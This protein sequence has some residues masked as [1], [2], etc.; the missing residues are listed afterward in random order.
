MVEQGRG[1]VLISMLMT[2]ASCAPPIARH[3]HYGQRD[4]HEIVDERD[5]IIIQQSRHTG[6]V[7]TNDDIDISAARTLTLRT[8][9]LSEKFKTC[10]NV[11]YS[12]QDVVGH[13]SAI[14]VA[15][16]LVLTAKHCLALPSPTKIAPDKYF[17]VFGY[18]YARGESLAKQVA[19]GQWH[20]I[21]DVVDVATPQS[22]SDWILVR[23][24]PRIQDTNLGALVMGPE[25]VTAEVYSLGHP[26]G[27]PLKVTAG[28][29]RLV[30]KAS[31]LTSLDTYPG[32]SG[33]PVFL[34]GSHRFV[35]MVAAGAGG[36]VQRGECF[37]DV[38]GPEDGAP[39]TRVIP[40]AHFIKALTDHAKWPPLP[41]RTAP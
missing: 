25:A 4:D 31:I 24:A 22:G 20:R 32:A 3:S 29:V 21:T 11:R 36:L 28:R 12:W 23:V 7:V 34:K 19:P 16:D 41:P 40:V 10:P 35:G 17:V 1:M 18:R 8:R 33:A 5:Q 39:G 26:L 37:D 9:Q 30:N 14:A 38:E 13:C 27:L 6:L 2:V 15:P